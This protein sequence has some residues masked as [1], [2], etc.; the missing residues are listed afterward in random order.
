MSCHQKLPRFFFHHLN[1]VG[2]KEG[3]T[4]YQFTKTPSEDDLFHEQQQFIRLCVNCLFL[5]PAS[6]RT[7]MYSAFLSCVNHVLILENKNT[8]TAA[9]EHFF[10]SISSF[11]NYLFF[12][13]SFEIKDVQDDI[14]SIMLDLNAVVVT[15]SGESKNVKKYADLLVGNSFLKKSRGRIFVHLIDITDTVFH[16]ELLPEVISAPVCSSQP[17]VDNLVNNENNI[18]ALPFTESHCLSLVRE[19]DSFVYTVEDA[20]LLK[21]MLPLLTALR[22]ITI[23]DRGGGRGRKKPLKIN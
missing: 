17:P 15:S 2:E 13:K 3:L 1:Y 11:P 22:E 5:C 9:V 23:V 21:N 8:S 19:V 4:N 7:A 12:P 6:D 14:L 10:K 18:I 20:V 16:S